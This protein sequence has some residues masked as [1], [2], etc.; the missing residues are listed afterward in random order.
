MAVLGQLLTSQHNS[1]SLKSISHCYAYSRV[2]A[3]NDSLT[4]LLTYL[5]TDLKTKHWNVYKSHHLAITSKRTPVSESIYCV[6]RITW[7]HST[8]AAEK[9]T[10]TVTERT[11]LYSTSAR[12]ESAIR[13]KTTQ[14]NLI[15]CLFVCIGSTSAST[16][17][18]AD[19]GY[20]K[21]E[22]IQANENKSWPCSD[23]LLLRSL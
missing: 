19:N 2:V 13:K 17:G 1:I 14:S 5:V 9:R 22:P 8:T 21:G 16:Y 4:Y 23:F 12:D 20:Q 3:T 10:V 15:Y 7:E 11:E 6:P 18:Y